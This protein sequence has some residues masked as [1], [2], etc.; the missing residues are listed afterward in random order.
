MKFGGDLQELT[1]FWPPKAIIYD[2]PRYADRLTSYVVK[3]NDGL[4][5]FQ[6]TQH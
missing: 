4:F 2:N 5:F 3:K 1:E 6:M